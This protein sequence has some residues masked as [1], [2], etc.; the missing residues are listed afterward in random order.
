MTPSQQA[1]D[2][3]HALNNLRGR[4]AYYGTH[5]A[6]TWVREQSLAAAR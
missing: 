5:G 6:P 3:E 2:V 4:I 1:V